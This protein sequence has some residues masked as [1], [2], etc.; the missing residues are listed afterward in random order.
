MTNKRPERYPTLSSG[1]CKLKS[2]W[3]HYALT[4]WL[5]YRRLILQ[6]VNQGVE[7]M[8]SAPYTASGCVKTII[9]ENYEELFVKAG[10]RHTII[11]QF[12]F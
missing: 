8:E 10:H 3:Q 1:A 5:K 12:H 11:W 4:E 9:L 7:Q 6:S 2:Q